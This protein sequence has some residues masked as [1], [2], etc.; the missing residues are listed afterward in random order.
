[1]TEE[2]KEACGD[3]KKAIEYYKK[4]IELGDDRP[5]T[6]FNLAVAYRL[7]GDIDRARGFAKLCEDLV[8]KR[9]ELVKN[10]FESPYNKAS[11]EVQDLEN[12]I[13]KFLEL[14]DK[15]ESNQDKEQESV[16]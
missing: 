11:R 8:K 5:E 6:Y 3:Y 14:L 15:P 4:A 10:T 16:A 2:E 9:K 13:S 1:M 12:E 7:M